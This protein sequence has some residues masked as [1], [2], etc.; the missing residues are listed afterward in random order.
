MHVILKQILEVQYIIFN[1]TQ[2][3]EAGGPDHQLGMQGY[4]KTVG[5]HEILFKKL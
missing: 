4:E 3:V 5:V 1:P 2:T